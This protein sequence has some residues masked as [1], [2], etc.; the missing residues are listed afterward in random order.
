MGASGRVQGWEAGGLGSCSHPALCSALGLTL[1]WASISLA[2]N[3]DKTRFSRDLES[4]QKAAKSQVWAF[5]FHK[6]DY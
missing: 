4:P 1:S 6:R 5:I 2:A 3:Q